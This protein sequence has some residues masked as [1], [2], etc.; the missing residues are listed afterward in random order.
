MPWALVSTAGTLL[1]GS[2]V[3]DTNPLPAFGSGA[4]EV[5]FDRPVNVCGYVGSTWESPLPPA[6]GTVGTFDRTAPPNPNAVFVT[7]HDSAGAQTPLNF[8]LIVMC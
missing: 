7:T 2:H 6:T 8:M 3:V 5:I 1:R 4:Y